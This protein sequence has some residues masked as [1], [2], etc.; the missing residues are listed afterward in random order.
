MLSHIDNIMLITKAGTAKTKLKWKRLFIFLISSFF[1]LISLSAVVFC[2]TVALKPFF[3]TAWI[4]S[5]SLSFSGSKLTIAFSVAKFTD[6]FFIPS[7]LFRALSR[8]VTQLWQCMPPI[9][10]LIILL[11]RHIRNHHRMIHLLV[12]EW[13]LTLLLLVQRYQ[14]LC[15]PWQQKCPGSFPSNNSKKLCLL[16]LV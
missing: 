4:I 12:L 9:C 8:T 1:L 10:K 2:A 3:T 15:R 11:I 14:D 7:T 6:A 16:F 13:Q 5:C